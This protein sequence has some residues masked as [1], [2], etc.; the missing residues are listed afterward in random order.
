MEQNPKKSLQVN[1]NLLK[2]MGRKDYHDL[3]SP[4]EVFSSNHTTYSPQTEVNM[5]VY[6]HD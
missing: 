2:D 5:S 6:N 1:V 4:A 3:N